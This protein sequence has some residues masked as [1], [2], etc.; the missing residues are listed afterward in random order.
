[1]AS[2]DESIEYYNY[3][4]ELLDVSDNDFLKPL[5]NIIEEL[6]AS[7]HKFT[8]IEDYDKFLF[9]EVIPHI[10]NVLENLDEDSQTTLLNYIDIFLQ[11]Y[12]KMVAY[13]CSNKTR[14]ELSEYFSDCF[15]SMQ[16]CSLD[17]IIQNED[18]DYVLV[19]MR[20]PSYVAEV[21]SFV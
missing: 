19:G 21:L 16:E 13:E 11:E 7:K 8:F 1:M 18:I 2:Y 5:Y 20:K 15:A 3:L 9:K 14:D 12:R 6:D 17:F 4:N 10:K